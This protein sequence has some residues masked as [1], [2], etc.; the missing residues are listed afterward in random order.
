MK[1][2]LVLALMLLAFMPQ[3]AMAQPIESEPLAPMDIQPQPPAPAASTYKPEPYY[4]RVEEAPAAQAGDGDSMS[5]GVG[6]AYDI[7][8]K[9]TPPPGGEDVAAPAYPQEAPVTQGA[10]NSQDPQSA[11]FVQSAPPIPYGSS[12]GTAPVQKNSYEGMKFCTLK[13]SFASKGAGID[14]RAAG[15][16]KTYLEKSTDILTYVE[17]RGQGKEG[18][19]SYCIDIQDH[20]NRARV[21]AALKKTLPFKDDVT[22]SLGTTTLAGSGFTT[23]QRA[24]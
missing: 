7:G 10:S 8:T 20:K 22:S 4:K 24:D 19:F 2:T 15:K 12:I 5:G 6:S 13:V 23:I 18:E 16:I 1:R 14:Q 11:P 17:A 3:Q 21:Y 9:A